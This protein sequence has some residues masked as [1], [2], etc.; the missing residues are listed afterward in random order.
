MMLFM[1]GKLFVEKGKETYVICINTVQGFVLYLLERHTPPHESR[2]RQKVI[3]LIWE[4]PTPQKGGT[5]GWNKDKN[6]F[7]LESFSF[8][9]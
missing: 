7:H 9:N 4:N 1:I 8:T 3:F 5:L 2:F 6:C